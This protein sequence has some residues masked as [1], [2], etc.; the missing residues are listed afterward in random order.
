M[1][2]M[3]KAKPVLPSKNINT[4]IKS[5]MSSPFVG[6]YATFVI[7]WTPPNLRFA[8]AGSDR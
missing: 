2:A 1:L 3:N 8:K 6:G 4:I 5:N 7:S